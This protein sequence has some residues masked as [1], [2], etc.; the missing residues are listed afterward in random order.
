MFYNCSHE[1]IDNLALESY[2]DANCKGNVFCDF[3][4]ASYVT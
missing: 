3:N 4:L 1:Y 2:F